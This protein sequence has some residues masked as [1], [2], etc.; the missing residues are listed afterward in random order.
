M[1]RASGFRIIT[2][3]PASIITIVYKLQVQD[4]TSL[5]GIERDMNAFSIVA[6]CP[7]GRKTSECESNGVMQVATVPRISMASPHC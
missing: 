6:L 3:G 2:Y 7:E 1:E 5:S 4:D